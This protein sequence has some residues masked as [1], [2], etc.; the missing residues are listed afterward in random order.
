MTARLPNEGERIFSRLRVG[1]NL[2]LDSFDFASV[3]NLWTRLLLGYRSRINAS[4]TYSAAGDGDYQYP[5]RM[6]WALGA[7]FSQ[8]SRP[9][10][11]DVDSQSVD[12]GELVLNSL[13]NGTD[14][15]HPA[16]WP[17]S[18]TQWGQ[19]V[20][21]APQ[22]GWALWCL[23]RGAQAGGG[24]GH[25]FDE[26]SPTHLSNI[27]A[28]LRDQDQSVYPHNWGLFVVA[29]QEV[30]RQLNLAGVPGFA[31]SWSRAII[32]DRLARAHFMHA[33][34]GWYSDSSV[35]PSTPTFDDY[36]PWGYL[37]Y[38]LVWLLYTADEP[39]SAT[40]VPG[41]GKGRAEILQE[42]RQFLDHQLY[43]FDAHGGHPE[44]GRSGSYKI[45]R[46]S[47][48]T[49]AYALERLYN[50]SDRW[51]LG[52]SILPD[53]L[54]VGR[55]RRMLRLHLNHYLALE[56]I[57]PDTGILERG[58][59]R[60]SS[61]ELLESYLT[62]GS[63]YWSMSTMAGLWLLPDSDPLWSAPE[64][65]LPSESFDY[66]FWSQPTGFLLSHHAADGH[67]ELFNTRVH[68]TT[69][70]DLQSKYEKFVYSSLLGHT[71]R[72]GSRLDNNLSLGT[73]WRLQPTQGD[74]WLPVDPED[75]AVILRSRHS[76]GGN[77]VQ[78]LIFVRHGIHVRVHLIS[79]GPG[80]SPVQEGGYAVG[81]S[82]SEPAPLTTTGADWV[83]HE[84]PNGNGFTA[85]L[86]GYNSTSES[87]GTAFHSRSA[88]WKIGVHQ[89]PSATTGSV[90]ASMYRA[91][92]YRF[93]PAST[94]AT[95]SSVDV[96]GSTV[97]VRWGDGATSTAP[98]PQ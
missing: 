29:N 93:D 52:F 49:F 75:P 71:T 68:K 48:L 67:V 62:P 17:L 77:T 44:F 57:N 34:E 19:M 98:F 82:A 7:W 87:A 96:A 35:S 51:N 16:K 58:I 80:A 14:P 27:H 32:D 28:F 61:P 65:P 84:S 20:V 22:V 89:A 78:S 70:S 9:R 23:R 59:T 4:R 53:S 45:A 40:V 90:F 92:R 63:T 56:A 33:G 79:S 74:R 2:I 66:S 64:E 8:P 1:D 73:T 38:Q 6:V 42:V 25:P 95:V 54:P 24:S 39:Q 15:A 81:H 37:L 26:L 55:I 97:T 31:A 85:R 86:L 10:T 18:S 60:E 43:F 94:R 72:S 13:R 12:V 69:G 88:G 91:S 50:T 21:E 46:L 5:T 36:N 41:S 3:R 11:L 76:Q 83:L 47:A 30:R